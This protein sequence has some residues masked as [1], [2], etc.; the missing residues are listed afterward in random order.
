MNMQ[1]VARLIEG[2]RELGLTGDE[3]T[4]FL[5]WIETGDKT[6]LPKKAKEA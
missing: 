2:L 1:E 6:K 4:D 3:V 5:L